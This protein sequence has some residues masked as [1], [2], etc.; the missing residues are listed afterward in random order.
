MIIDKERAKLL[1]IKR[2]NTDWWI[3]EKSIVGMNGLTYIA[4][5]NDIGEIRVKEIDTK[6]SKTPSRDVC[7]CRL[8]CTYADEHNSPS[9]CITKDGIII[10]SYTGHNSSSGLRYRVTEKPYDILSFGDEKSIDYNGSVT[11]AQMFE[12]EKKNEIWLFTRV[13]G[14]TWQF[15]YSCDVCKSWSKP[16]TII[17]SDKGGLYY[18]N[19]RKQLAATGDIPAE[20]WFF[21]IYGH[22]YLSKDHTIRSAYIDS[23]GWLCSI[24]GDKTDVNVRGNGSKTEFGIDRIEA[25]YEA[26]EGETVRLLSVSATE[27]MRIGIAAFNAE[28]H[29]KADYYIIRYDKEN[30][31]W[32]MSER[33]AED[34]QF[35]APGQ[36]DGSQTYVGGMEFYFGVG[37]CGYVVFNADC[38]TDRVFIARGTKNESVLESY[39]SHDCSKTYM[40]E[41]TIKSVDKSTGKKLWRPIV[42][43]FAQDNMPVYWHEGY[44]YA[45]SGGWHCDVNMYV[46]YDD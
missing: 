36:N 22:P 30:E 23:D 5:T 13:N 45:H 29:E 18:M 33:I 4:Y 25:V 11:Y 24:N 19:I 9:M 42:P 7:L 35:L 46:E 26:P 39:V 6:C 10:V 1:K 14:V 16:V 21:A 40:L 32:R 43:V 31:R 2:A 15:T 34:Y 28:N 20:R 37:D 27:P 41:Q 12:N 38:D 17:A 8:N 3:N 44:Y